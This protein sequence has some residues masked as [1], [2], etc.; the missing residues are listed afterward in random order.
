MTDNPLKHTTPKRANGLPERE[1]EL[2]ACEFAAIAR[3]NGDFI[4]AK[5]WDQ[6]S[7]ELGEERIPNGVTVRFQKDGTL[8]RV[9]IAR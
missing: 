7:V 5:L 9:S 4:K 8:K 2:M 1:R 6:R 3:E